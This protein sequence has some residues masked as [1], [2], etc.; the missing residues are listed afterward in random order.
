MLQKGD[1][2]GS[3]IKNDLF[4]FEMF[5]VIKNVD[6]YIS[7]ASMGEVRAEDVKSIYKNTYACNISDLIY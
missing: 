5:Q 3:E 4:G 2:G 7:L 1:G 6:V